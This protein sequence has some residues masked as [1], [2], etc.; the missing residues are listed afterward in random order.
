MFNWVLN[1]PLDP[2]SSSVHHCLSGTHEAKPQQ[3]QFT[4]SLIKI[5]VFPKLQNIVSHEGQGIFA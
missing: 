1:M 5:I 3:Q 4:Y 2:H